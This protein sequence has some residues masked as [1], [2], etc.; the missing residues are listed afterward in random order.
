M[1]NELVASIGQ[2]FKDNPYLKQKREEIKQQ[3]G[4]DLA[5]VVTAIGKKESGL[6][7]SVQSGDGGVSH[8]AFQMQDAA[9]QDAAKKIGLD[10]NTITSDTLKKDGKTAAMLAAGYFLQGYESNGND[11]KSGFAYYNGGP[12]EQKSGAAQTYAADAMTKL[13]EVKQNS[14]FKNLLGVTA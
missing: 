13:E 10:P 7:L 8:G 1:V 12:G 14:A 11:V 2:A 3:S 5:E 4:T 9:R 6:D